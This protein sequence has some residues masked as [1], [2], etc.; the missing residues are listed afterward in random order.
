M[1]NVKKVTKIKK[2]KKRFLHLWSREQWRCTKRNLLADHS[3]TPTLISV[4]GARGVYARPTDMIQHINATAAS[5]IE[6]RHIS[7]L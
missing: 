6:Q 7:T 1:K 3:S 5:V 2:R 4:P